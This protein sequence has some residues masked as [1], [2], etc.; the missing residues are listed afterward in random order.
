MNL[1]MSATATDRGA[2]TRGFDARLAVFLHEV[3]NAR[4]SAA[5]VATTTSRQAIGRT[6]PFA[7]PRRGRNHESIE[8]VLRWGLVG[9][10]NTDA[11]VGLNF[12]ELNKRSEH[13]IIQEIGTGQRATIKVADKPNP[14]GR[15]T[16]GA[17]YV[18]T[19]KSQVGRRISSGLVFATGPAGNYS[20]PGS[21]SGQQ[22]YLRRQ[23]KNVPFASRRDRSQPGIIIGREIPG[24]HFVQA[25]GRE[26]FRHYRQSVLAA[27]RSQLRKRRT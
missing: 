13:W 9:R 27:A 20:K 12:T 14:R 24:Q 4:R 1:T 10:G 17:T 23:I 15:P 22:L 25:G 21:A 18:R 7:P 3:Q 2:L 8:R 6:R 19:V 16:A 5:Q 26:G 11:G